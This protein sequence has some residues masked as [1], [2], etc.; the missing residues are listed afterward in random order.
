MIK[1]KNE[2]FDN[3]DAHLRKCFTIKT[4]SI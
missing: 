1:A 4:N 3:F 2:N